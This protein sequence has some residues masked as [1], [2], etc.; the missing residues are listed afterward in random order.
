MI[1][2]FKDNEPRS[3]GV[4]YNSTFE[5]IK[6]L[7][8]MDPEKAGELAISAIELV[9][10][11]DVSSDDAMI[12]LFLEPIKVINERNQHNYEVKVQTQR[13]KKITDL[14]LDKIAEL[15]EQ[16]YKQREIGERLGLSQQVVSYRVSVIKRDYPELLQNTKNSTKNTKTSTNAQICTKNETFVQT[17]ENLYKNTKNTNFCKV[18]NFVSEEKDNS[19]SDSGETPTQYTQDFV[20]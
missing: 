1:E 9:L 20:F 14:K 12:D 15:F 16:G 17:P 18:G 3:S 2:F 7:Y 10:T 5:Q 19:E 8:E 6:K 11:G 13:N 4:I